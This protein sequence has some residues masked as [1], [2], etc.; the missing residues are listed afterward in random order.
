[1][2]EQDNNWVEKFSKDELIEDIQ[3]EFATDVRNNIWCG[4]FFLFLLV[5]N[6]VGAFETGDWM[7]ELLSLPAFLLLLFIYEIW[8][9]KKMS[10]CEDAHKLVDVYH[11]Y[12][13]ANKILGY[14][15]ASALVLYLCYDLYSDF[16]EVSMT[17]T[18][19][20]AVIGVIVMGIIIWSLF[21][22]R[23]KQPVDKEID[24][25]NDLLS[26]E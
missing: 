2:E 9:K 1:M 7:S 17:R 4:S 13:K 26:K 10:K 6:L 5:C 22:K 16:G 21:H 15:L 18:I 23:D 12:N 14:I 25:L 8:W 11:K 24:R 3:R 20:F 19:V